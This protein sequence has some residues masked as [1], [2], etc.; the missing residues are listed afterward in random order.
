MSQHFIPFIPGTTSDEMIE[1]IA[2]DASDSLRIGV[3]SKEVALLYLNELR[4]RVRAEMCLYTLTGRDT[5]KP[6]T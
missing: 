5:S 1:E 4:E 3:M 2:N 6:G